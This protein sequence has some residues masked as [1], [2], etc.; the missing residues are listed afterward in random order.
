[1]SNMHYEF[2]MGLKS[3]DE[4]IEEW[5]HPPLLARRENLERG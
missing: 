3:S 1:M 5:A 4:D 2:E